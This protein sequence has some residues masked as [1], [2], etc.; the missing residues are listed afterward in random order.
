[1]RK[2]TTSDI[3]EFEIEGSQASSEV[4]KE[5]RVFDGKEQVLY[6]SGKHKIHLSLID[7][8]ENADWL[9]ND[10]KGKDNPN[11]TVFTVNSL[12][13][14][15]RGSRKVKSARR[16][17]Q[18][19]PKEDVI[20]NGNVVAKKGEVSSYYDKYGKCMFTELNKEWDLNSGDKNK[21]RVSGAE[22]YL[23]AYIHSIT[24][25]E[26]LEKKEI[27]QVALVG[28]NVM[29]IYSLTAKFAVGKKLEGYLSED[30]D[31]DITAQNFSFTYTK[32]D[33]ERSKKEMNKTE[34]A[35][36]DE[37][38][39]RKDELMKDYQHLMPIE[40]KTLEEAIK[41]GDYELSTPNSS[42]T[43]ANGSKVSFGNNMEDDLPPF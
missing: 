18:Y 11:K 6:P 4:K 2:A 7:L 19:L 5:N 14:P 16:L 20:R 17:I 38:R 12:V 31:G 9:L 27:N 40:Y 21:Y 25:I 22:T 33:F 42:K 15:F 13:E 36:I 24:D 39:A 3:V 10:S 28:F 37:L 26:K 34:Q 1:M 43:T 30:E 41:N 35:V 32:G 23:L 29:D 8:G